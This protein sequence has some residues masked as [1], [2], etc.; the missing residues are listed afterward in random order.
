MLSR[1][2]K[3]I[4]NNI[5]V[6][7]LSGLFT[8]LPIALTVFIVAATY[9]V[10]SRWL[11]PLKAIAPKYLQNIPGAEFLLVTLFIL[12]VG[13]LLRL[14]FITPIINWF[15]NLINKIPIIRTVYSSSKSLV[16]FF[17]IPDPSLVERKVI[18]IEFPRTGLF[19]IAFL[20]EPATHNFQPLIPEQKLKPGKK[21][22][23][24]FMPNSPNPTSGYFLIVSEDEIVHTKMT[25]EEAIKAVVSCGLVTPQ[26]IQK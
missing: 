8:I 6:L 1:W 24:V 7:F 26:S 4:F 16:D 5:K 10:S 12:L 13:F 3:N 17:N 9:D 23:K 15:E 25:F 18:L 14:F 19:N 22:Y 2:I 20:L 11:R 21:Y